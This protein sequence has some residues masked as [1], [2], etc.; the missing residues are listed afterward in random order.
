MALV[1]SLAV[2]VGTNYA[3]D[4]SDGMRGTDTV[5][6][7]PMRLVA[8]GT[9]S[10]KA[11]R[12][13]AALAFLAAAV[14]GLVVSLL[15]SPWLILLG[16]ACI[17]AGVLYTGGPKPYGYLG[18]GECFVF[19]FFGPVAV[20]GTTYVCAGGLS[21]G[22]WLDAIPVGLFAVSLLV[23]NNLRDIE[24]DARVG[25]TTLAVVIGDR[26]TR[27]FYAALMATIVALVIGAGIWRHFAWLA[28]CAAPVMLRPTIA[29]LRGA[30]GRELIAV[31]GQTGAAQLVF[32]LLFAVGIAL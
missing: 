21:A 23:V 19:V 4:Y 13:A 18:L 29:V 14:V 1:V 30:R 3:N 2:Q 28:L 27:L 22:A 6:V 20:L 15:T 10:A 11:V 7:G 17:A 5:R 25:K 12:L 26:R 16:A 9:A 8:S 24:N 31:L 32:G